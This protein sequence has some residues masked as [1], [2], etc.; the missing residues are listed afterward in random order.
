[1]NSKL[2]EREEGE[3]MKEREKG[4]DGKGSKTG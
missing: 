4:V 3:E 1:M 2:E